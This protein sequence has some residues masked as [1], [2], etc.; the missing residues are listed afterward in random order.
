MGASLEPLS[1]KGESYKK[2]PQK[3]TPRGKKSEKG[4]TPSRHYFPRK[5]RG[6]GNPKEKEKGVLTGTTTF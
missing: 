2:F 3:E 1:K 5:A 6:K 4:I